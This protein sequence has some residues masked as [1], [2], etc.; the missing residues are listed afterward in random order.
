[1]K[2]LKYLSFA[3]LSMFL[4]TSCDSGGSNTQDFSMGMLY[5]ATSASGEAYSIGNA[6]FHFDYSN[7]GDCSITANKVM[8]PGA[9]NAMT[10]KYDYLTL[11]GSNTGFKLVSGSTAASKLSCAIDGP[12]MNT[13]FTAKDAN[14]EILAVNR[15]PAFYSITNSVGPDGSAVSTSQGDENLFQI[16][17]NEENINTPNRTINFVMANARFKDGELIADLATKNINF[18]IVGDRMQFSAADLPVYKRTTDKDPLSAYKILN[19]SGTGKIGGDYSVSFVWREVD[20]DGNATDY[21]VRSTLKNV[22]SSTSTGGNTNN[23]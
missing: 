20:S 12:Y 22:L 19:L 8:V 23:N 13:T 16:Q 18:K 15:G 4:M 11:T 6:D 2:I 5:Y 21:Q 1:M 17:I 7:T 9:G 14:V 3:A 10:F